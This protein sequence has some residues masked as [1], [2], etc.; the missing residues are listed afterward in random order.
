MRHAIKK[1]ST[2]QG[3]TNIIGNKTK[4]FQHCDLHVN[5]KNKSQIIAFTTTLILGLHC[6]H[7]YMNYPTTIILF[8]RAD[9]MEQAM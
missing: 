6:S 4:S 9:L 7:T 2:Q 5:Y 3:K 1:C 8:V